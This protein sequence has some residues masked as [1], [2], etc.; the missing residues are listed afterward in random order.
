MECT[1]QERFKGLLI[2][3]Q[4]AQKWRETNAW[5]EQYKLLRLQLTIIFIN[6]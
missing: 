1:I 6:D 4:T 5:L 3:F 2:G